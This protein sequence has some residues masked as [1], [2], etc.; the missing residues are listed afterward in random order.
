MSL[1]QSLPGPCS[2]KLWPLG[3]APLRG[4]EYACLTGFAESSD[5]ADGGIRRRESRVTVRAQ[6][7]PAEDHG[8]GARWASSASQLWTTTTW[9]DAAV[10]SDPPPSLIIRNR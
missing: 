7:D 5:N 2:R 9:A 4:P 10:S 1:E 6:A 8:T 3:C